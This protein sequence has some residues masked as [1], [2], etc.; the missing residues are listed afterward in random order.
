[1]QLDHIYRDDDPDTALCGADLRGVPEGNSLDDIEFMC[2]RC[3]AI[4]E[5]FHVE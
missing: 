5:S 2:A 3:D 1:M 4:N